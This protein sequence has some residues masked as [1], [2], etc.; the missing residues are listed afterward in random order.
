MLSM[1]QYLMKG[2]PFCMR[3]PNDPKRPMVMLPVKYI[4]EVK[5]VREERLSF[6]K[7]IDKV[8]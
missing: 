1:V 8:R 7:H 3:D 4:E 5:W 6:W 2:S